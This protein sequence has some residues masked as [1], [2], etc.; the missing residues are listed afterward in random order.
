VEKKV[1]KPL[2]RQQPSE[3]GKRELYAMLAEAAK[4][5]D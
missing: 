5:T 3:F 4:N 2:E 1:S